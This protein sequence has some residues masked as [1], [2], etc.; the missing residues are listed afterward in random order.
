[1]RQGI[2][3]LADCGMN[4]YSRSRFNLKTDGSEPSTLH[5]HILCTFPQSILHLILNQVCG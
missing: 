5:I 4:L 2:H 3:S 1:M